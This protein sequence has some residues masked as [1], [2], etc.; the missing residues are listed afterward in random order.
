MVRLTL[1]WIHLL[2]LGFG[3]GAVLDRAAALR[4][5]A[6]L[7]S[8]RRAFRDDAVWGIA[9]FLWIGSGLWRLLGATEKSTSYYLNNP[10]FLGKMS[11]LVVILLL[12]I[13]PMITLARWR[14]ALGRSLPVETVAVP[15]VA[16]RIA[17]I[18]TIE[19]LLIMA[20]VATAVAMARGYGRI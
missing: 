3:L 7:V 10:V 18:S 19:A 6:S 13:W 12:E 8:V 5:P 2:A 1:A 14:R 15:A 11:L 17:A 16:R 4:E 9:A 20:M